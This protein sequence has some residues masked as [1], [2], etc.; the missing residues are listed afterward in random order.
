M[1]KEYSDSMLHCGEGF[2]IHV[3]GDKTFFEFKKGHYLQYDSKDFPNARR[4]EKWE[5]TRIH[6]KDEEFF[7]G[8]IVTAKK[9]SEKIFF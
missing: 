8:K 7:P 4:G 5:V 1:T 3:K 2:I 9:I 6:T